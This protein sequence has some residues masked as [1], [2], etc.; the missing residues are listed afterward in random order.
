MAPSM[1]FLGISVVIM[2]C[3]IMKKMSLF[4]GDPAPFVMELPQYHI[5]AA[6]SLLLHIWERVWAFIKK[7]GTILFVCCAVMWFLASFGFEGG[8]FGLVDTENSLIASM[9]NA[10]AFIFIP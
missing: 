1:Y 5:P 8:N 4:A 7:A 6:K 2:S 9:G 3:I 10:I